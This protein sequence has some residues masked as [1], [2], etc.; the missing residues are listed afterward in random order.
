MRRV[1]ERLGHE[2]EITCDGAEALERLTAPDAA[3]LAIMDWMMPELDGL[4]VCRR[5]KNL[6]SM[7]PVYVIV[8]T[9][10]REKED[11]LQAF[12]AGADDF[13]SKPFD[14][15]EL[16]A[17]LQVGQRIIEQQSLLS[18]LID[19]IPDLIY[20]SDG[21]GRCLGCN[22]A[23]AR[24]VGRNRTEIVGSRPP[25][26][27][28]RARAEEYR[29]LR[30]RIERDEA[31]SRYSKWVTYPD[32]ESRLM[33]C[34]TTPFHGPHEEMIGWIEVSRD[35][36]E[37]HRIDREHRRLAA[38]VEQAAE[39]IMITDLD[40]NI[41]YVNPAFQQ[42]TGYATEDAVG[43]TPN[44][45]KSGTHEDAYYRKI[46]TAL[47]KGEIWNGRFTNRGKNGHF[48][49][50]ES[51]IFP[52]R[53]REG[54]ITNYAS[55]MKDVTQE[56]HLEAQLRQAQKMN[57]VGQLAGG[58]AHDF[59]NLLM[60]IRNSA[61]FALEGKESPEEVEEDLTAVIDAAKQAATLTRQLLA[62]SRKQVLSPRQ[63]DLNEVVLGLE[64]ML[65]RVI[66]EN[67][68]IRYNVAEDPCLCRV[69]H[70]Q[71]EQVI[72]NM[73]VNA[74]DAMPGGGTLI[75]ETRHAQLS[76]QDAEEFI[77]WEEECTG[78]YV[79]LMISDSGVGMDRDTMH[80]IFE[81]F[82]TTKG[83]GKGTGLGLSTAYG[84]I[85]QHGGHISVYSEP[86]SGTTFKVYLPEVREKTETAGRQEQS[87][88]L[89]GGGE[90]I[91]IAEDEPA[92]LH[93]ATRML[94]L[95][96]YEVLEARS[97][98]E[99]LEV[100]DRYKGHVDLLF[101]D[102]VMPGMDGTE[103]AG[104]VSERYPDIRVLFASGYSEFHVKDQGMIHDENDLI[105]KP[106]VLA[107]L[108]HKI[109]K[110]LGAPDSG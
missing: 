23:F 86:G 77:E 52:I 83:V 1:L 5:V 32:G 90:T 21:S 3:R 101:A 67:I 109:R 48:F 96:G 69:D 95:L 19:S 63:L 103:L 75:I 70:G 24:Y 7:N 43:C 54:E 41:Q 98:E 6:G 58:V 80:H 10:R 74:R 17:R 12:E 45:L 40:G 37:R 100:L 64:N 97:G 39:A 31:P 106:F 81:P 9:A 93:L 72:V 25:D 20:F 18:S 4:D 87:G 104:K 99:A 26:F 94:R 27:F 110:V 92:V 11:L 84:I 59:N 35:I 57:A 91:L 30:E 14:Q 15:D 38:V 49:E 82:F 73:A 42:L 8:L 2:V 13:I 68:R 105:Q 55:I 22:R 56:L 44:I 89:P 71:I 60:V 88:D 66:P 107:D 102:V 79:L 33:D 53:N 76:R 62:F 50:A 61:Q 47:E 65:Q 51:V 46:W 16:A 34:V 108:A 29:E 28:D 85:K 78:R 36:T